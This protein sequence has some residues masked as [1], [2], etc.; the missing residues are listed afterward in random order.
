[1]KATFHSLIIALQSGQ[2]FSGQTVMY[3]LS[4]QRQRLYVLIGLVQWR[5]RICS[6]K[7][8]TWNKDQKTSVRLIVTYF[9][10]KLI[11]FLQKHWWDLF[12]YCSNKKTEYLFFTFLQRS[13]VSKKSWLWRS[14]NFNLVPRRERVNNSLRV[15]KTSRPAATGFWLVFFFY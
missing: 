15:R 7:W 14:K 9:W 10:V 4:P 5:Q 6:V 12:H 11:T 1:M 2:S 13:V 3:P 8:Q